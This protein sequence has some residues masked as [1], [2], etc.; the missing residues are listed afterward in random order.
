MFQPIA[1]VLDDLSEVRATAERNVKGT[2]NKLSSIIR[3]LP[4]EFKP[5]SLLSTKSVLSSHN[6]SGMR[7]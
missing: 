2:K 3:R 5:T 1:K 4:S 7:D 6:Q